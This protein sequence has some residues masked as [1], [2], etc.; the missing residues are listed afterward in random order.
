MV[1]TRFHGVLSALKLGK[2]TIALGY[3]HKHEALT[4]DMGLAEFCLSARALDAEHLI[5][6]FTELGQRSDELRQILKERNLRQS[7]RLEDQFAEISSLISSDCPP[8][9]LLTDAPA[10]AGN[11]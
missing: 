7:R 11:S 10:V 1:A 3:S 4:A 8:V 2:P 6:S 5:E 9:P